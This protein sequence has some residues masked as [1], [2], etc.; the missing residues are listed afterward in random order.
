MILWFAKAETSVETL[1]STSLYACSCSSS[2]KSLVPSNI[3]S[4]TCSEFVAPIGSNPTW[5]FP[6]SSTWFSCS[7]SSGITSSPVEFAFG[8]TSYSGWFSADWLTLEM[9]VSFWMQEWS[10]ASLSPDS[11][12]SGIIFFFHFPWFS[13]HLEFIR[14]KV[15]KRIKM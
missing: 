15:E 8:R 3:S 10:L 11:V 1:K 5:E 6:T 7:L 13:R 14:Y 9:P 4:L 12:P 2:E